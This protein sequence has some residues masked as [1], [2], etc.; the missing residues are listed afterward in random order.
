MDVVKTMVKERDEYICQKCGNYVT[1]SAC[2]GSHVI[3][4]SRGNALMFHPAN[5]KVLCYHDHINW[6]HKEPTASG[7]W[8]KTKF[9][10]R[11]KFL[12]KNREK[13]VHWKR[14]DFEEMLETVKKSYD[15]KDI[16]GW[17]LYVESKARLE[18]TCSQF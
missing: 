16:Q 3:P 11:W 13:K 18:G 1:G 7:E 12:K 17:A 6:F 4:V 2:H 10:E 15:N 14:F 8:F 5:L 9:P